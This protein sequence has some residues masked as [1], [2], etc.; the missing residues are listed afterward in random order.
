MGQTLRL[1]EPIPRDELEEHLALL[2]RLLINFPRNPG[3]LGREDETGYKSLLTGPKP[4][5][6]HFETRPAELEY[7]GQRAKELVVGRPPEHV[8]IVARTNKI[9]KDDYQPMLNSLGIP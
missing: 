7:V 4:E 2:K 3:F 1:T 5:V 6:H 9:L 8:C